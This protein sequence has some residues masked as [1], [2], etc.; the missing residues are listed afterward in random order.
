MQVAV[1]LLLYCIMC[2]PKCGDVLLHLAFCHRTLARNQELPQHEHKPILYYY[3]VFG[4]DNSMTS[5]TAAKYEGL[6]QRPR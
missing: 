4:A 1:T 3:Q 6:R 5:V 2:R